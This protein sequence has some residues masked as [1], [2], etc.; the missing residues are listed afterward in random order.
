MLLKEFM[1]DNMPLSKGSV[2]IPIK[3]IRERYRTKY[4]ILSRSKKFMHDVYKTAP[5]GRT[6]VHVK[7]PSETVDKFYYDVL[8]EVEPGPLAR[9][10]EQCNVKF[11]SNCPSFVYTYAYIF[12]HLNVD[13]ETPVKPPKTKSAGAIIPM[14]VHKI[15]R[16]RLL[17]P[18]TEEKLGDAVLDN[19]PDTR[20]PH[21]LIML[22]KSIYYAI[23]YLQD[24][25]PLPAIMKT[26]RY[27]TEAQVVGAVADFD[28]LMARRKQQAIKQKQQ[29]NT[30]SVQVEPELK[31]R[32]PASPNALAKVRPMK[33]TKP[34]RPTKPTRAA[35]RIG[36]N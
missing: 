16:S 15:P 3:G 36:G 12:Y 30:R 20:N 2:K 22:D 34:A 25:V 29:S 1:Q 10:L 14:L 7:V 6:I 4:E 32:K 5:G 24:N 27:R 33:P 26:R 23:F 9:N 13:G 21:R 31:P 28:T 17:M 35:K 8:L 18:G 11:F 19:A